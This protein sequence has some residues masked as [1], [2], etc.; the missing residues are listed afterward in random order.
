[1]LVDGAVGGDPGA[2]LFGVIERDLGLGNGLRT[3]D[4]SIDEGLGEFE[5]FPV[6]LDGAVI[7]V[8]QRVL[9]AQFEVVDGEVGLL[10]E[11]LVFKVGGAY[12]RGVLV[13]VDRAADTAP[14]VRLPGDI[15][16][17][18]EIGVGGG[19]TGDGG[20]GR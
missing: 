18:G 13:F 9:T 16:G 17:Q 6:G 8:L 12:L 2:D 7:Q 11:T 20:G 4:A 19:F 1:M 15:E 14:E 10:G 3:V 5:R